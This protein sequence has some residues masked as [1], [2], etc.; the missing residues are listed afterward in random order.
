M[1]NKTKWLLGCGGCGGCMG[2]LVIIAM[3]TGGLAMVG[4]QGYQAHSQ[5]MLQEFYA[6]NPPQGYSVI[7]AIDKPY[8][9]LDMMNIRDH[10]DLILSRYPVSVQRQD[11]YQ[12]ITP[13][14]IMARAVLVIQKGKQ[15][16]P[17]SQSH[18][19]GMTTVRFFGHDYPVARALYGSRGNPAL[20]TS[21]VLKDH[22]VLDVIL[23]NLSAVPEDERDEAYDTLKTEMDILVER[24][25]FADDLVIKSGS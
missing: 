14:K 10:R 9:M 24:L 17:G 23:Q 8:E 19:D 4:I 7:I 11:F 1:D 21:L 18:V 25:A 2:I 22:R 15:F 13:D 6:D 16:N 20:I 5:K 3:L 12:K